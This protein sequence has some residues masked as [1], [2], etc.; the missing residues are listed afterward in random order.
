MGTN[1]RGAGAH[2]GVGAARR[3]DVLYFADPIQDKL[4]LEL[5]AELQGDRMPLVGG[6]NA[7]SLAS[8]KNGRIEME[9]KPEIEVLAPTQRFILHP[10]DA[11]F[12]DMPW[13]GVKRLIQAWHKYR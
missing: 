12:P 3:E 1:R 8:G 11:I 5:A 2:V 6:A 9:V 13:S 10:V 7:L 4:S